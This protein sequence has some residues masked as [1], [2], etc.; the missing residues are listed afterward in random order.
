MFKITMADQSGFVMEFDW[1][2]IILSINLWTMWSE[3]NE[4][5]CIIIVKS[6][7]EIIKSIPCC[8]NTV[9]TSTWPDCFFFS[10]TMP[11]LGI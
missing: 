8:V 10:K 4:Y 9:F 6:S 7:L 11:A 1:L 5:L 3:I 2:V